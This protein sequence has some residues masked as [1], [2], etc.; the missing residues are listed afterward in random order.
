MKNKTLWIMVGCPGSGKT[1]MATHCMM[2]GS[3][4]R[5]ISRDQIRYEFLAD[6]EDYFAHENEVFEIF[7]YK[8]KSALLEEG[9]FNVI[10]DATHLNWPSRRKLLT[11]LAK[12]IDFKNIAIIPVI[13]N[14]DL[15]DVQ[16]GNNLRTGRALVPKN[17]VE[18]MWY[19]ITPP[20]GDPFFY[21][22]FLHLN[23]ERKRWYM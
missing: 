13:I 19:S 17:I 20:E 8:I 1:Y 11:A 2:K 21:D 14:T 4:W 3:G 10:A 5:H 22:G 18:K 23:N 9:I 12:E 16:Y 6:D 7:V 15:E